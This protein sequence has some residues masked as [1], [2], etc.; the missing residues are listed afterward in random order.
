MRHRRFVIGLLSLIFA[1]S[2][3]SVPLSGNAENIITN[4][5]VV[6]EEVLDSDI[7]YTNCGDHI[8]IT[9]FHSSKFELDIPA[10]IDGLP[11]TRIAPGA[12]KDNT[13]LY[14]V[15]LPVTIEEIGDEAFSGC[16]A[17]HQ[18]H[19]SPILQ[20]IGNRAFYGCPGL[21]VVII[22]D[23]VTE[24]GKE[25]FAACSLQNV[26]LP[27]GLHTIPQG[28]FAQNNS[29][30]TISIPAGVERIEKQAFS[31]CDALQYICYKGSADAWAVLSVG[32]GNEVLSDA[33]VLCD[34]NKQK[35]ERS[36][37][38]DPVA[39]TWSF[40][41]KDV[42][43]YVLS[44]E[45]LAEMKIGMS[46]TEAAQ[47]DAIWNQ[48]QGLEYQGTC[49]GM[50]V[51]SMLA[52]A[53]ILD[54]AEYDADATCLHDVELTDEVRELLT[55]YLVLQT[56]DSF[57]EGDIYSDYKLYYYLEQGIP[58][59]FSFSSIIKEEDG[60]TSPFGHA[61]VAYGVEEGHYE[62]NGTVFTK[63]IL[64]YDSNV[65]EEN[66]RDGC[67]YWDAENA[68]WPEMMVYIPYLAE[69]GAIKIAPDPM[70]YSL[71][72]LNL[73]GM[74]RGVGYAEPEQKCAIL[75]SPA[76]PSCYTIQSYTPDDAENKTVADCQAGMTGMY[77]ALSFPDA[78]SCYVIE[79]ND[80]QELDISMSYEHW[81]YSVNGSQM[82]SAAFEPDGTVSVT[83]KDTAYTLTMVA[84]EG[85]HPTSYYEISVSGENT[86][87]L[88]IS[89][90]D[91][92]Y[93]IHGDHLQ[94]VQVDA[95]N[96][97]T[98]ISLAFSTEAS[99]VLVYETAEGTIAINADLDG[100]GTFETVLA[101]GAEYSIGDVNGDGHVNASDASSILI[102]S[103]EYGASGFSE[104]LD[105][106]QKNRAD[107]DGDGH[108]NAVDACY[109]LQY[110]ASVG[111]G[112]NLTMNEFMLQKSV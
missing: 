97:S 32:S 83:G 43:Y 74:N 94:N 33:T 87:Q 67:I 51:T 66:G 55:Y 73:H 90:T 105:D 65:N 78:E 53:G 35:V 39:D 20:T 59:Y 42:G 106:A 82:D 47:I 11:V 91:N 75:R 103:A 95:M 16:T 93:L 84:D 111:T 36:D 71:D 88:G 112:T 49:A 17:L 29:L 45:R 50:A 18:F 81:W 60:T 25:A 7:W 101:V 5:P 30:D 19:F 100:D 37:T 44:D 109:V 64:T 1:I 23:T 4:D 62:F 61:V 31:G 98:Q 34:Y 6:V 8:E 13:V 79:L 27:N 77:Q 96:D 76:L 63:K 41:N 52:A 57:Y 46:N 72:A 22:P 104:H 28:L 3:I 2:S 26:I 69:R 102:Y 48:L 38:Y 24:I 40:L 85:F 68:D 110:S 12:C 86:E 58:V 10:E 54:P 89:Q 56:S 70:V 108:I 21:K 14:E 99:S 80:M 15:F 9:G 92:G 107:V